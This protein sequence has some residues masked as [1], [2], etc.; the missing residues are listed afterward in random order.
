[1]IELGIHAKTIHRWVKQGSFNYVNGRAC[2]ESKGSI[3]LM[4]YTK[5]ANRCKGEV[6]TYWVAEY[7]PYLS[8]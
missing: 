6:K 2:G 7:G 8:W 5:M 4:R 3:L 1:V